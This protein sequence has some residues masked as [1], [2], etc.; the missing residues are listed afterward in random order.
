MELNKECIKAVL[1]FV[2]QNTGIEC[3]DTKCSIKQTN[4]Y[5]LI[6]NLKNSYEKEV[7]IHST[8]YAC[9]CGYLDMKPI[10]E[11]NNIIYANCNIADVTPTGYQFLE[12]E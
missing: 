8:I 6:E 1:D 5:Q 10:R 11:V 3:E 7:I 12:N 9:K 2:I 4:L